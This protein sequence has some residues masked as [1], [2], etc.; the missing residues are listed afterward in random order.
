MSYN[1]K[2]I[3]KLFKRRKTGKAGDEEKKF[4]DRVHFV[5]AKDAKD[6]DFEFVGEGDDPSFREYAD[7]YYE[8]KR[9]GP[10]AHDSSQNKAGQ[11]AGADADDSGN[12]F[13]VTQY[14]SIHANEYRS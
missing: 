6:D 5:N 2:K 8:S 10:K 14:Q 13:N 9:A 11:A 1:V 3:G 12:N 7:D 4:Q